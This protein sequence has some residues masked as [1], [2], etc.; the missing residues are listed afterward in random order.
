MTLP[1]NNSLILKRWQPH[2]AT[3]PVLRKKFISLCI[4]Q[5]KINAQRIIKDILSPEE[6]TIWSGLT[7]PEPRKIQWLLGRLA[8]KYVIQQYLLEENNLKVSFSEVEVVPDRYGCPHVS[9]G[10]LQSQGLRLS[11]SIS[12]CDYTSAA[13]VAEWPAS[14][15]GV[16]IDIELLGDKHEGLEAGGFSQSERKILRERTE[17][18]LPWLLRAWCAKE[19]LAKSLGRGFCGSPYTIQVKEVDCHSGKI[20]LQ[21]SGQLVHYFDHYK[22]HVFSVDTGER[23]N[24]IYAFSTQNHPQ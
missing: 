7:Y 9:I 3:L 17:N 12:H 6:L 2:A 8:A 15:F 18:R 16:G 19:S 22:D 14:Q 11:L 10:S 20:Q 4:G 23:D 24:I 21:L 5:H 13:L 1:V